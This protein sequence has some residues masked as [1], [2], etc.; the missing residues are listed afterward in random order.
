MSAAF[1]NRL[2]RSE[3]LV[4]KTDDLVVSLKKVSS[5]DVKGLSMGKGATKFQLPAKLGNMGG[6]DVN[7]MVRSF[8]F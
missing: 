6:G 3:S 8:T 1:F 4:I 5:D 7:A 2:V